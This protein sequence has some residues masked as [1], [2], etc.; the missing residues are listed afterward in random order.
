MSEYI[1]DIKK[2][3]KK[4][5]PANG[6]KGL[7]N[8]R[9]KNDT[10]LAL[11]DV[12]LQIKRGEFFVLVGPNGAGKT[13]L[14]KILAGLIMPTKGT[15]YVNGHDV[16]KNEM[17]L[18]ESIG[19]LTGEERSFYWRLTGRENLNFFASLYNLEGAKAKK[20]I[21]ELVSFLE[22]GNI[23]RRFQ[24]YSTGMK[25]R[26]A[27]ARSLLNDPQIILMDEPTKNLDPVAADN[28]K[29][30]I[31]ELVVK[32]QQKT[33]LLSTHNL[34]EADE[35]GGRVAILDK[36]RMKACGSFSDLRVAAGL[37]RDSRLEDTFKYYVSK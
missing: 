33:V 3:T 24:E 8:L 31:K 34:R 37:S 28:L 21:E 7:F 14:I 18:K 1:I 9:D 10:I 30:T 5:Y 22:I 25:Q 29:R 19:L 27:I 36:G 23:D 4:F 20:R 15:V 35:S 2:L 32:D 13:T 6:L 11:E 26:I 12:D 17:S 16:V